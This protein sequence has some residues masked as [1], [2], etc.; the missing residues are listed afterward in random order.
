M[1][2]N[3]SVVFLFLWHHSGVQCIVRDIADVKILYGSR[4]ICSLINSVWEDGISNVIVPL[5]HMVADNSSRFSYRLSR[6][7]LKLRALLLWLELPPQHNTGSPLHA[8]YCI[9]FIIHT[10]PVLQHAPLQL[11]YFLLWF[12]YH[13]IQHYV[14]SDYTFNPHDFARLLRCSYSLTP[15][16][17]YGALLYNHGLRF[18]YSDACANARECPA[19]FLSQRYDCPLSTWPA[20]DAEMRLPSTIDM[21]YHSASAL[22][23]W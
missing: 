5:G 23:Q 18:A 7:A 19:L 20:D 9:F 4:R 14:L 17:S 22:L 8:R 21:C 6:A 15:S 3:T 13:C 10:D 2:N 11:S 12:T 16:H 1:A